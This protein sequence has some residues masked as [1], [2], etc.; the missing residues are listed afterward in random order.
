MI[1]GASVAGCRT[2][3]LISKKYN[4]LVVEEHGKIGKPVQCAGL[5]SWRLLELLPNLPKDVIVNTVHAAK[6][7]SPSGSCFELKSKKPVN[8]INRAK[9][10][11]YLYKKAKASAKIKLSTKFE[12]FNYVNE[13]IEVI[14]N[15]GNFKAKLLVGADGANSLVAIKAGIKR[16]D[17]ALMGIQTTTRGDFDPD[18]V[19]LWFGSSIAPKFFAWVIPESSS[20]AR[21]GLATKINAKNYF[22]RFLKRRIGRLKKPDVAGTINF[23]LMDTAADR[24]MLVGDAACQV[25]PFSGG[26][27]IYGL[28]GAE[29]CAHACAK[30]LSKNRFDSKFLKQTYD[31]KWKSKLEKPIKKGLRYRKIL[32]KLSDRQLNFFFASGK[33]LKLT[34][35][36]ESWD[37]DLL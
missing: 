21:I 24:L 37:M 2:A 25:K 28:I 8:V 32:N 19:E 23:G 22:E 9:F 5:V 16:S 18:S 36:L 6:F 14:T 35:I 4:V 7:F 12:G 1:V 10:D 34:K 3:E 26:G 20:R 29:R 31:K 30:A 17:N 15:K 13:S 33:A 11:K 27:V